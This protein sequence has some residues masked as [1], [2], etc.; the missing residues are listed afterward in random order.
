MFLSEINKRFYTL[1][2][3]GFA[4]FILLKSKQDSG[5]VATE[6]FSDL[7]LPTTKLAPAIINSHHIRVPNDIEFRNGHLLLV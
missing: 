7:W 1:D 2:V 4:D 5:L 3:G 6:N